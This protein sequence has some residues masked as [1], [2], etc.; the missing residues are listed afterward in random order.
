LLWQF[1]DWQLVTFADETKVNRLGLRVVKEFA[2]DLLKACCQSLINRRSLEV[3][4]P[5][6]R[7]AA[8]AL[9]E[10]AR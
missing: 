4:D 9:L 10:L 7:V 2:D 1:D 6:Y 5:S 8:S 3:V